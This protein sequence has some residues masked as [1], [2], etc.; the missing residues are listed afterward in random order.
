MTNSFAEFAKAS[1][2]LVIGS[3]MTEAHPVAATFLKNAVSKGAK[4]VVID[5][6]RHKLVEFADKHLPIKSGMDVALLNALMHVLIRDDLY[7][8]EFVEQYCENFTLKDK[9]VN[10]LPEWAGKSVACS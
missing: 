10:T 3:N 5:P 4:L 9:V 8:K 2:F 6:R 1:M 7:D